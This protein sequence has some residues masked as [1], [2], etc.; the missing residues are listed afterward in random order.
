M[1]AGGWSAEEL[2]LLHKGIVKYPGG[3][4]N[5]WKVISDFIGTKS[6]KEVIAKA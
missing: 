2:S 6:V 3:V 1:S 4:T 5:R